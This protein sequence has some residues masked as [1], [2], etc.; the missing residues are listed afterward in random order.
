MWCA[1]GDY[2]KA[3]PNQKF[4][5]VI[6]VAYIFPEASGKEWWPVFLP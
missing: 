2:G 6:R 4:S 5:Q 1:K 3:P